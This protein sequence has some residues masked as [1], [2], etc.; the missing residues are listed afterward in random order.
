MIRTDTEKM[1]K[2]L[3][4]EKKRLADEAKVEAAKEAH[5]KR[6]ETIEQMKENSVND[7]IGIIESSNRPVFYYIELIDYWIYNRLLNSAQKDR[8]LDLFPKKSTKHNNKIRKK[9]ED[10]RPCDGQ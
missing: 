6:T 4:L 7:N 10:Y 9:L 1:I 5:D 8:L 3:R 2:K